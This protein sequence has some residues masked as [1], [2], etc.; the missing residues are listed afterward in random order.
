MNDPVRGHPRLQPLARARLASL[1]E[2][3]EEWYA[4]LPGLLTALEEQWSVRIGRPLPGGS[5]SFVAR[6]TRADGPP[7]VVKVQS[8]RT[9]TWPTRAARWPRPRPRVRPPPRPRPRPSRPAARGAGTLAGARVR[10]RR[11][12][13]LAI[14]ADTLA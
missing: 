9:P 14:L 11:S 5:A 1:G 3:G 4:A 10:W 8:P 13:K 6:A 12:S 2:A 7:L